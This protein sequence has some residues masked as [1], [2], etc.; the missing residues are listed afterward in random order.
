MRNKKLFSQ[1][2]A[3]NVMGKHVTGLPF[4]SLSEM[5]GSG[6][7]ITD[8]NDPSSSEILPC[9]YCYSLLHKNIL[10][11]EKWV[12]AA[13]NLILTKICNRGVKNRKQKGSVSP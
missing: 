7:A 9:I 10:K 3:F 8:L 13:G 2:N 6:L 11:E 12:T 4:V 5:L 1:L